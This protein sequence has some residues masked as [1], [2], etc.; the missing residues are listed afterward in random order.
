MQHQLGGATPTFRPV[1]EEFLYFTQRM[2]SL[3]VD[4]YSFEITNKKLV[5]DEAFQVT[6]PISIHQIDGEDQLLAA[7]KGYRY[8]VSDDGEMA[9]LWKN[10]VK[11]LEK[12]LRFADKAEDNFDVQEIC[13]TLELDP[14]LQ[15]FQI[16]TDVK[17]QLLVPHS[18]RIENAEPNKRDNLIVST[19]SL[20]EIMYFLSQPIDVP[21]AHIEKGFVRQTIDPATGCPFDWQEIFHDLFQIHSGKLPPL[22]AAVSIKYRGHWFYI[23][24]AD[25]ESKRTFN[26]LLELFNLKIRAGGGAQI[27]LLTI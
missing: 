26:L 17:G 14:N 21:Q 24:D 18:R 19:R 12:I 2:R 9:T 8:R 11:S 22:H 20:K 23:D 15:E 25:I 4:H 5:T 10:E 6:D 27:P 13:N 7:E 1:F 3:Q 16:K